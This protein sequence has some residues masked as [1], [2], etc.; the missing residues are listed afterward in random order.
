MGGVAEAAR[1]T[2]LRPETVIAWMSPTANITPWKLNMLRKQA[3]ELGASISHETATAPAA[4][5]P[6]PL[7]QPAGLASDPGTSEDAAPTRPRGLR[8]ADAV[9]VSSALADPD[10]DDAQ[11]GMPNLPGLGVVLPFRRRSSPKVVIPGEAAMDD[12]EARNYAD[13][14]REAI[15]EL[16][17]VLDL[18]IKYT[19]K[20]TPDGSRADPAIWSEWDD[21]ELDAVVRV[22]LRRAQRSAAAAAVVR[23]IVNLADGAAVISVFADKAIQTGEHYDEHGF[24][25]PPFVLRIGGNG[26]R[27]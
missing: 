21:D 11:A 1:H 4:T 6:F 23:Q 8:A 13:L 25:L 26:G 5:P 3:K 17:G 24:E 19:S 15:P 20:K 9:N 12:R 14:L 22:L 27:R 16:G 2:K 18:G 7:S 10:E